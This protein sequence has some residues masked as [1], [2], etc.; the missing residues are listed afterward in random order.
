MKNIIIVLAILALVIVIVLLGVYVYSIQPRTESNLTEAQARVIAE[1]SCI[2]GGEALRPGV[3]DT[4]TKT[5]WF[6]ANLNAT[7]PGFC[8]PRCI[9]SDETGAAEINRD[10]TYL[11][12]S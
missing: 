10:C 5:W 8:W 3:Y 7:R 1:R 12:P 11:M 9:V 2:K 6:D 4:Y